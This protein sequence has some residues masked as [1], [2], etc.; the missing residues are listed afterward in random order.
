MAGPYA[1]IV[2]SGRIAKRHARLWYRTVAKGLRWPTDDNG[3]LAT[4][5]G[6]CA[7]RTP[8]GAVG[9]TTAEQKH[10]RGAPG[11]SRPRGLASSGMPSWGRRALSV[12]LSAP[13]IRRRRRCHE[14]ADSVRPDAVPGLGGEGGGRRKRFALPGPGSSSPSKSARLLLV[15]CCPSSRSLPCAA[16]I[17]TGKRALQPQQHLATRQTPAEAV[18]T[19][20]HAN[21]AI[22]TCLTSRACLLTSLARAES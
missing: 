7:Q 3:V 4:D 15:Q 19:P 16:R 11:L 20:C 2:A 1:N 10:G 14:R 6:Q 9:T 8:D 22:I 12:W 17:A 13:G 5:D 21:C 18:N